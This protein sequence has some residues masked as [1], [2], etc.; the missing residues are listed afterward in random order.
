[1]AVDRLK[2]VVK[3]LQQCRG[4]EDFESIQ[5]KQYDVL[6]QELEQVRQM[7]HDEAAEALSLLKDIDFTADMRSCLGKIVQEKVGFVQSG[8]VVLQQWKFFPEF[9]KDSLW[10]R[11]MNPGLQSQALTVQLKLLVEHLYKLGLRAPN[12]ET[13][14]MLTTVLLLTDQGRFSDMVSLRSAYL[15]TKSQARQWLDVMK[16]QKEQP[17]CSRLQDLPKNPQELEPERLR[18]V[19]GEGGLP[20]SLPTGVDME[21]LLHLCTL[22]P[23]RSSRL[24]THLQLQPAMGSRGHAQV[25]RRFATATP[26]LAFDQ[27]HTG[28]GGVVLYVCIVQFSIFL[29]VFVFVCMFVCLFVCLF[30][31]W[32]VGLFVGLLVCWFVG[33]LLSLFLSFFLS[34]FFL[35]FSFLTLLV[36]VSFFTLFILFSTLSML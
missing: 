2:G 16:K 28:L 23:Q 11:L 4:A 24:S 5:K 10:L 19:F 22:V 34:F 26:A 18:E 32:L 6:L 29:L 33:L 15:S 9:L 8:R 1:M 17:H 12:E 30:V 3:F 31:G 25:A 27:M 21:T 13:F 20:A 7:N 14:A 36:M 35:S